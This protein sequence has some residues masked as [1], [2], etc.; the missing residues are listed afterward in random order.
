LKKPGAYQRQSGKNVSFY[1]RNILK[2]YQSEETDNLPLLFFIV[3]ISGR[4]RLS[5]AKAAKK[6]AT[7]G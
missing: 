7:V 1:Q 2:D 6:S 5:I 3:I 4:A